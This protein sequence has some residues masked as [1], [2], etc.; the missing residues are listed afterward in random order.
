[1]VSLGS[2]FAHA[3]KR[4]GLSEKTQ[5]EVELAA[6]DGVREA[7]LGVNGNTSGGAMIKLVVEEYSDRVELTFEA[8]AS[9]TV[10][11]FGKRL[12]GKIPDRIRSEQRYGRL[13]ITLLK[14]CGTARSS[15]TL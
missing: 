4:A 5:C 3:A 8:P 11:V 12:E 15:A 13:R 6:V 10:E 14:S 2:V 7:L 9:A 1:V